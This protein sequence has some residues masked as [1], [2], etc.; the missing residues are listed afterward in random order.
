MSLGSFGVSYVRYSQEDSMAKKKKRAMTARE[1]RS[2]GGKA[3]AESLS[4]E[5][6]REIAKKAIATRWA[7]KKEGD[8]HEQ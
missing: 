1:M 6:R 4:P 3:R 7:R 2:A 8:E 5:R